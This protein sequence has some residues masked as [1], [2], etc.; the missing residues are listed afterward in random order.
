MAEE[1]IVIDD[2][3][4]LG[5]AVGVPVA[6]IVILIILFG[7]Y[8]ST[9]SAPKV[10]NNSSSSNTTIS[11]RHYHISAEKLAEKRADLRT[12]D[13]LPCILLDDKN[14]KVLEL[15]YE[16]IQMDNNDVTIH[17]MMMYHQISAILSYMM[18]L[19]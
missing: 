10:S 15:D 16:K 7:I 1:A 11:P 3:V 4:N 13:T 5:V 2:D 6:L 9:R 8:K 17:D 19:S 14:N 18:M 12:P